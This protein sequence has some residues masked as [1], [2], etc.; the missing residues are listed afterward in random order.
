ML[1]I[2]SWLLPARPSRSDGALGFFEG[3]KVGFSFSKC[4]TLI[5]SRPFIFALIFLQ[6]IGFQRFNFV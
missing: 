6:K 2:S 1:V 4:L 3:A 5:S